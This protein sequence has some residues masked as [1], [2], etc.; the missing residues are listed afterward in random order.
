MLI[1]IGLVL[2]GVLAWQFGADSRDPWDSQECQRRQE[3][4][5]RR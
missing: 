1:L 5:G 4:F 3:W 2:F